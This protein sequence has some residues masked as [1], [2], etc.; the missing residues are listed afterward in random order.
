MSTGKEKC[1]S[2]HVKRDGEE[3]PK[4]F[5]DENRLESELERVFSQL[6]DGQKIR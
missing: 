1:E 4:Y 6:R 2:A 3:N 5:F